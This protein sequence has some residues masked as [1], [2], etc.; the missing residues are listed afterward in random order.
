V[1]ARVRP[2]AGRAC[3]CSFAALLAV[4][5]LALWTE[6]LVIALELGSLVS[7]WEGSVLIAAVTAAP[8]A[9]GLGCSLRAWRRRAGDATAA[10]TCGAA[11]MLLAGLVA[12]ILLASVVPPF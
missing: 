7:A 8:P 3:R 10:V 9:V 2:R 6:L 12:G 4:C 5:A 1:I 11:A